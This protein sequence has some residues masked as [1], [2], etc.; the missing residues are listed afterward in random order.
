MEN[1]TNTNSVSVVTTA[2]E[3]KEFIKFPY[4]HYS[5]DTYWVPPLIIEQKKLLNKKKNPFFN[6]AE[7]IL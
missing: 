4:N 2:A 5:D 1:K 7:I 3:K 6:N